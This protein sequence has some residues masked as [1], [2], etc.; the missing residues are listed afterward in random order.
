M[1]RRPE[2]YQFFLFDPDFIME[3]TTIKETTK[4]DYVNK[5]KAIEKLIKAK[6]PN[7]DSSKYQTPTDYGDQLIKIIQ[8]KYTN[9]NT[10]T[11]YFSALIRY[12]EL[13][14]MPTLKVHMPFYKKLQ[15]LNVA[16]IKAFQQ[17]EKKEPEVVKG[18]KDTFEDKLRRY[19]NTA[20]ASKE[21]ERKGRA[22]KDYYENILTAIISMIPRRT[23]DWMKTVYVNKLSDTKPKTQNYLYANKKRVVFIFN[24]YKTDTT[25]GQQRFEVSDNEKIVKLVNKLVKNLDPFDPLFDKSYVSFTNMIKHNTL[26]A[27]GEKLSINDLRK[28]H[29]SS[30][31]SKIVK[32]LKDDSELLGHSVGTKLSYYIF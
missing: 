26:K 7:Y 22:Y 3:A 2:N 10:R 21:P 17:E 20:I 28:L 1:P 25:Y 18:T 8:E 32:E 5:L 14:E 24:T 12:Y 16:D 11:N 19:V 9:K 31:F 23:G 15:A 29:S 6:I 13:S 27:F 4:K 30:K